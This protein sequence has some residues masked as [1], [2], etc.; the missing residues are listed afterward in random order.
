VFRLCQLTAV[1]HGRSALAV[2]VSG[3]SWLTD[4]DEEWSTD[5]GRPSRFAEPPAREPVSGA[6]SASG[7]PRS[8]ENSAEP[9][10]RRPQGPSTASGYGGD[11]PA[12]APKSRLKWVALILG[13]WVV[14]SLIVLFV[15]LAV[16]GPHRSSLSNSAAGSTAPNASS[17]ATTLTTPDGWVLAQQDDQTDCAAHSYGLMPAF[18]AK[19][20]CS[21][22]HRELL[23]TNQ[24]GRTIVVADYVVSFDTAAQAAAFSVLVKTDGTGNVSDLLREGVKLSNQSLTLSPNAAFTSRQDGAHV[25]VAEAAY[26]AGATAPKDPGLSR[27]AQRAIAE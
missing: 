10:E 3:V 24:G 16:R 5:G 14:V 22:V 17:T 2:T 26:T 25:R 27:I 23:T 18:F 19:T 4:P 1:P 20:P 6:F 12:E 15:L 11:D 8:V 7:D 9:I 21:N 13:G